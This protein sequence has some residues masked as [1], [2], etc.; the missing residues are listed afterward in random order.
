MKRVF[1]LAMASF[2]LCIFSVPFIAVALMV[3]LTS[4]GAVIY[5][6]DR[7]TTGNL[8]Q[9]NNNCRIPQ[10]PDSGIFAFSRRSL[11]YFPAF[12][13][14]LRRSRLAKSARFDRHR[15]TQ[16]FV[17]RTPGKWSCGPS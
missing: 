16:T 11:G 10:G 6:S 3:E 14:L 2:L 8:L 12:V 4:K 13:A 5:W 17:Q 9:R 1:D 7:V 15:H